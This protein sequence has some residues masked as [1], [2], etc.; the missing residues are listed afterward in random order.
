MSVTTS[1]SNA[2]GL[3]GI[4]KQTKNGE[5]FDFMLTSSDMI[6]NPKCHTW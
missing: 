3:I 1:M 6:P 4:K 5:T 2:S